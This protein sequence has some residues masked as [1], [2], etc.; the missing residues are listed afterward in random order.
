MELHLT[1]KSAKLRVKGGL[2]RMMYF[3]KKDRLKTE[4]FA[5]SQLEVI[6]L[7]FATSLSVPVLEL[8]AKNDI[9]VIFLDRRGN[10]FGSFRTHN[11]GTTSKVEKAQ[12][13]LSNLPQRIVFIKEWIIEKMKNQAAM[14]QTLASRRKADIKVYLEEQTA[15]INILIEKLMFIKPADDE[16]TKNK[17]RGLEGAAGKRFWNAL[18]TLLPERYKFKSR[19]IRPAQD[20]FNAYLNYGFAVLYSKVE[21][22]LTG[23]GINPHLGFFHRNGYN[24]KSMVYDFIEP[25]RIDLISIVF[26]L[27][28]REKISL[29]KHIEPTERQIWLSKSGKKLLIEKITG[30]YSSKKIIW[31]GGMITKSELITYRAKR[32]AQKIMQFEHKSEISPV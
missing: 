21:L 17:M 4:E 18:N 2:F 25:F 23:A 8:A 22:A 14:L 3:D 24:L 26:Q 6:W 31:A 13:L 20:A 27:F 11:S 1:A 30:F 16:E 9:R 32:F 10:P 29:S 5:P 19:R 28:I 12:A 15:Q 7:Y